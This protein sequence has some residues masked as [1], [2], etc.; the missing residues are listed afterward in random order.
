MRISIAGG[1]TDLPEYYRHG[2][3][4]VVAAA[5]PLRVHVSVADRPAC[6]LAE[7]NASDTTWQYLLPPADT[8]RHP[9]PAAAG[10]VLGLRSLPSIAVGSLVPPG[11][12][13]GG[14]GAYSVALV[15]ALARW[16]GQ[17][18]PPYRTATLAFR[19]EREVLGRTIGQQDAWVAALGGAQR[20]GFE[21]DGSVTATP[22]PALCSALARLID[23]G[24]LLYRVPGT[25]DASRVLSR[26]PEV[27]AEHHRQATAA[28]ALTEEAFLSGDIAVV[29]SALRAHWARKTAANPATDHPVCRRIGQARDTDG[30][31]GFKLIGAGGGGHVLIAADPTRLDRARAFLDGL[32]LTHVPLRISQQG[33]DSTQSTAEPSRCEGDTCASA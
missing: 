1:G 5:L 16:S 18:L 10:V 11:S 3:T 17:S 23:N 12:G 27:T 4:T 24:L 29:G 6:A 33:L 32:G 20:L 31:T 26:A 28:A 7:L 19:L 9:Y 30:I 2:P 8:A 22:S 15:D 14:S 21:P 13:L 25:R